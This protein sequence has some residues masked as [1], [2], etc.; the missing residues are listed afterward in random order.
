MKIINIGFSKVNFIL[1][2]AFTAVLCVLCGADFPDGSKSGSV[3][4]QADK[5]ERRERKK[6][7][8]FK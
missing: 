2:P 4:M 7:M 3:I 6:I 8:K 5:Q 1:P